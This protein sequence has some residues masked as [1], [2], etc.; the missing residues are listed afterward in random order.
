M[1]RGNSQKKNE[2]KERRTRTHDG[3]GSASGIRWGYEEGMLAANRRSIDRGNER[4][5]GG[6]GLNSG[7]S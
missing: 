5:T 3:N 1:R 7:E 2:E 6:D 4:R